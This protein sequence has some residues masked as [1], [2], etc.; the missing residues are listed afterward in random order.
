MDR[1]DKQPMGKE[2]WASIDAYIASFPEDIQ[3]KLRAI[4]SLVRTLV[5]EA[6]EKFSYGMPTFYYKGN[7]V[8]FAAYLS[9]IGFYPTPSG[10]EAFA[11]EL[12]PYKGAKGSVQFPLDRPLPLE[13]I[14]RIVTY[15]KLE[16]EQQ[17]LLAKQVAKEKTQMKAEARMRERQKNQENQP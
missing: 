13:L 3:M 15:R 12:S 8:H 14:G 9:H 2:T 16:N 6:S 1:T 17:E 5:P 7:L 4:R 10:I 11:A